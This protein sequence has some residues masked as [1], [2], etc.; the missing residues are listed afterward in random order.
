MDSFASHVVRSLLLLLS[1]SVSISASRENSQFIVRS[2]KSAAWKAKQGVMKSV[3]I[4]DTRED[5][6]G[7]GKGRENGLEGVPPDFS[8]MARHII[9]VFKTQIS[10][11]EVRAMAA[12]KVACPG[13]QVC[14][15][16]L[17]RCSRVD[18]ISRCC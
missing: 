1:P 2:K 8:R 10:E 17:I 11:N 4:D 15:S 6:K 12:S 3:F 9:E 14:H 16:S 5:G 7:K 13:L 18:D